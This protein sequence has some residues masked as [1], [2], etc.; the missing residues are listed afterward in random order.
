MAIK[1]CGVD[2]CGARHRCLGLCNK[3]YRRLRAHGD[4]NVERPQGFQPGNTYAQIHGFKPGHPDYGTQFRA[5]VDSRR[6]SFQP[7]ADPNRAVT[8]TEADNP[9]WKGRNVS[10]T[11]AHYRVRSKRGKASLYAC[12]DCG[13]PARHWSYNRLDPNHLSET[14]GGCEMHYSPDTAFYEPRCQP[15]HMAFDSAA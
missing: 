2:G 14:R 3:H 10:Y 12:V 9:A 4:P 1:I 7:G 11:A 6:G 5:G 13:S 15:C 8:R